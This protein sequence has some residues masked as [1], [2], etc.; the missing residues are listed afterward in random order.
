MTTRDIRELEGLSL[1]DR[2]TLRAVIGDGGMGQVY[3]GVHRRTRGAVA[4]KVMDARAVDDAALARFRREAEI[5]AALTH[6]NTVRLLDFG[7]DDD[8]HYIVLEHVDGRDLS[9]YVRPG[10]QQQGFVAHTMYQVASSLAEAHAQGVV[11]RDVKPSNIRVRDHVGLPA[12]ATVIDWGIARAAHDAGTGTSGVLGTLGYIAPEQ[13]REDG[14]VDARSDVY[15]LGCVAYELLAGR[16]PFDGL[17]HRTDTVTALQAHLNGAATP[18]RQ[19]RPSVLP[20]LARLV[21]RMIDRDPARRPQSAQQLV[22]PLDAIK[23][24]LGAP[25]YH[26]VRLANVSRAPSEAPRSITGAYSAPVP[27]A[28]LAAG[29]AKTMDLATPEAIV[30]TEEEKKA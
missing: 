16:L 7:V 1:A 13:I 10:G 12:F 15:A 29:D 4:V 8:L 14:R 23:G 28:P 27:A 25:S 20:E 5:T 11:H 2:Y 18:L 9:R 21:M 22:D 30:L 24:E 26:G 19:A 17:T 3:R 6:P